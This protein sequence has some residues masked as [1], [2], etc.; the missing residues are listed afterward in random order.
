MKIVHKKEFLRSKVW[1]PKM[2]ELVSSVVGSCVAC[3]AVVNILSQE[4]I[5]STHLP[6]VRWKAQRVDY[7]GS[8]SSGDYVLFVIDEYSRFTG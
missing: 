6:K 2:D 8:L 4:P 3:Q 5:K 1:F 7:H